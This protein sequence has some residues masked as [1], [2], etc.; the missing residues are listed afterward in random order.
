MRFLDYLVQSPIEFVLQRGGRDET[1]ELPVRHG[2]RPFSPA[3]RRQLFGYAD[4]GRLQFFHGRGSPRD[5][6]DR[7]HRRCHYYEHEPGASLKFTF[8]DHTPSMYVTSHLERDLGVLL[9]GTQNGEDISGNTFDI[10]EN[11]F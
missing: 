5:L 7:R 4:R 10:L 9:Q 11:W 1:D 8:T 2:R 3:G 6:P